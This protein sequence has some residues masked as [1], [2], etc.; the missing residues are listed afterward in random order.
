MK[1]VISVY[2]YTN[3][4]T[5]MN[6]NGIFKQSLIL[7]SIVIDDCMQRMGV[8][9]GNGR[10]ETH[11]FHLIIIP[12]CCMLGLMNPVRYICLG[13]MQVIIYVSIVSPCDLLRCHNSTYTFLWSA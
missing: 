2:F 1:L 3:A 13:Q 9:V 7:Y 4:N 11:Q 8:V 12:F 5:E 6:V 10:D